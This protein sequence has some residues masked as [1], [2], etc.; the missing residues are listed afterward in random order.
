MKI[1]Y[2]IPLNI[3]PIAGTVITV[4]LIAIFFMKAVSNRKGNIE[5]DV[6]LE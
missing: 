6:K 2:N 4:V 3:S 1:A 5:V